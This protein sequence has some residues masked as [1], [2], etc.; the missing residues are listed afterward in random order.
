MPSEAKVSI[1]LP[2]LLIG[3][4]KFLGPA[5][6][7]RLAAHFLETKGK[8]R[9]VF[10][11]FFYHWLDARPRA[12][13]NALRLVRAQMEREQLPAPRV[14]HGPY[15]ARRFIPFRY[16][17]DLASPR[18]LRSHIAM[19]QRECRLLGRLRKEFGIAER[20]LYVIHLG[21]RGDQRAGDAVRTAVAALKPSLE[22]CLESGVVLAIENV[23]DRFGGT[24]F[25]GRTLSELEDALGALGGGTS[26]DAPVGCTFDITHALLA[27]RGDVKGIK[28]ALAPLLPSLVHLHVNAP[29]RGPGKERWGD[30]HEAPTESDQDVWDLL[31]F[32]A[33]SARFREFCTV[34]YEVLWTTAALRPFFGGSRLPE[35][36]HGYDLVREVATQALGGLDEKES[37]PYTADAPK[38]TSDPLGSRSPEPAL[39]L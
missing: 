30:R 17:R 35:V 2:S 9:E 4:L 39:G 13:E 34:T 23:T 6:A 10:L 26:P 8:Q 16:W 11:P 27:Y 32:A 31:R 19:L 3:T 36:I 20:I 25:A 38:P 12:Q 5:L 22:E 1:L 21:R 18:H 28:A 24:E 14:F 7:P 37:L 15:L 33:T 29:Y